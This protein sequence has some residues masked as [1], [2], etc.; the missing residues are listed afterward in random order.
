M[1][2]RVSIRDKPGTS[3]MS[4]CPSG[5]NSKMKN[6]RSRK[7]KRISFGKYLNDILKKI[8]DRGYHTLTCRGI[9]I[10]NSYMFHM[11]DL[12][13]ST[14]SVLVRISQKPT[15]K[16][17]DIYSAVRLCIPGT[18]A[19]HANKEGLKA[20]EKYRASFEPPTGPAFAQC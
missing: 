17:G 3:G 11:L 13:A 4:K 19:C 1:S 6:R 8:D 18:L 7:N 10:M 15:M 9:R 2:S 14:A 20:M 12:I 5:R 16:D